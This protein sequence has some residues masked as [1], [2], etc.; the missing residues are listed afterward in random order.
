MVFLSGTVCA[1]EADKSQ[2][3]IQ[4][5]TVDKDVKLEVLDW[6]GSGRPL[7]LLAGNGNDAHIFDGFALPAAD[8]VLLVFRR[9]DTLPRDLGTMSPPCSIR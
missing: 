1:Q 7:V 2:H 3:T 5:I 8:S 4:F 6:G 9:P